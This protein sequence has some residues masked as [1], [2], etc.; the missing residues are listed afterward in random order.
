MNAIRQ[1]E[2]DHMNKDLPEF[3]I[4]DTVKVS[5]KIREGQKERIQ[6]FQGTIISIKGGGIRKTLKVRRIVQG[7]GVERTFPLHS[8]KL[9]DIE[10]TRSG[11]VR[12]SKLYYL[13]QRVGKG[14]RVRQDF[15]KDSRRAQANQAAKKASE[16]A[17]KSEA[18]AD[19]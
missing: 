18:T 17:K 6:V 14:T 5:Y 2:L 4:G 15:A 16:T 7:E 10:I 8:P 12:R 11:K 19:E 9:A 13:R 1:I 3:S